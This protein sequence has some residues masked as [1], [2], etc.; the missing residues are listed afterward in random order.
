MRTATRYGGSCLKDMSSVAWE[1][2][3]PAKTFTVTI[4]LNFI[5][6][7]VS[8]Q[9]RDANGNLS[10]IVCDD[11]SVEGMPARPTVAAP[12]VTT[13]GC[14]SRSIARPVRERRH[15]TVCRRTRRHLAPPLTFANCTLRRL[16][17]RDSEPC[18]LPTSPH[19][20]S[21]HS[22]AAIER[23]R[24]DCSPKQ[25]LAI[26]SMPPRGC[27]F[28]ARWTTTISAPIACAACCRSSRTMPP[29]APAWSS[30]KR[31]SAALSSV[32]TSAARRDASPAPSARGTA[33]SCAPRAK[34]KPFKSARLAVAWA[35]SPPE[36]PFPSAASGPG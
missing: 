22:R 23:L 2:F 25:W 35:G 33:P 17:A 31:N 16:L 12:T 18:R 20:A 34:G 5:G 32:A 1:P 30:S 29:R 13:N 14:P 10:P 3:A 24:A 11:I 4:G 8:A 15:R 21:T 6:F 26:R 36:R 27:G 9:F 28:P 7:Y 19:L